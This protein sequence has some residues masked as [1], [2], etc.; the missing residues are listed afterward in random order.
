[1]YGLKRVN[2]GKDLEE[3][4]VSYNFILKSFYLYCYF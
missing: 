3:K 1:M 4:N 2:V